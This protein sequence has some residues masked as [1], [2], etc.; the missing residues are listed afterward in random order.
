MFFADFPN[1]L[2]IT[3]GHFEGIKWVTYGCLYIN[4]FVSIMTFTKTF[5]LK[6]QFFHCFGYM[7]FVYSFEILVFKRRGVKND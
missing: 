2:K 3:K 4:S 5:L 6:F 1:F 7:I